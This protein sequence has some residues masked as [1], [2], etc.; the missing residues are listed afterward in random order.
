MKTKS[1]LSSFFIIF[2]VTTAYSQFSSVS[3]SGNGVYYESSSGGQ[4]SVKLKTPIKN[5]LHFTSEA[6]WIKLNDKIQYVEIPTGFLGN[7]QVEMITERQSHFLTAHFG[8]EYS[9]LSIG[10]INVN[11]SVSGGF[12]KDQIDYFG[13]LRGGLTLEGKISERVSMGI[14]LSYSYVTWKKDEMQSV[15]LMVSYFY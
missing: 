8:L 11:A 9:L 6:S 14:P 3:L 7:T 2:F 4:I 12:F 1:I 5:K 10:D 15:G 13:I